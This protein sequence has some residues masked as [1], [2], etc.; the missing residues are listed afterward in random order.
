MLTV[1]YVFV[2]AVLEDIDSLSDILSNSVSTEAVPKALDDLWKITMEGNFYKLVARLGLLIAVFGIGFWCLK[3]YKSLEEGALRPVVNDLIWPILLVVLLSNNGRNMRDFTMFSRDIMNGINK[4]TDNVISAE[5][6][7]QSTIRILATSD[8]ISQEMNR[9][10][11]ACREYVYHDDYTKC[12]ESAKTA[13]DLFVNN[14]ANWS[15]SPSAQVQRAYEKRRDE[16]RDRARNFFSIDSITNVKKAQ[17]AQNKN[18]AVSDFTKISQITKFE[19]TA[20][21]RTT[22]LSFRAAFIYI[23]EVMMLVTGIFGPIFLALS[24]FPVGTKPL[25]S[26]AI[27]FVSLGFCKICFTLISGLSSLAMVFATDKHTDMMV[28]S[29]V[30]GLLSPALA[31]A[32]ASGSGLAA[33]TTISYVT[34]GFGVNPGLTSGVD[35]TGVPPQ[36]QQLQQQQGGNT[37]TRK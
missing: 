6:S 25:T 3:L 11:E 16:V 37:N 28:A 34:P 9:R 33:L 20:Q 18:A 8:W 17:E 5:V 19:D 7:L 32:V 26:W 2:S 36:L 10:V 30:L 1:N 22:I 23:I 29:I 15:N 24:I 14:N 13:V 21:L 4:S 35:S 27:S 12:M 31:F